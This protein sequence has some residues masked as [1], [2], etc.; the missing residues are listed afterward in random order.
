M[1]IRHKKKKEEKKKIIASRQIIYFYRNRRVEL[2]K[3]GGMIQISI[4]SLSLNKSF[5]LNAKIRSASRV[6]RRV[7]TYF[8][9][10]PFFYNNSQTVHILQYAA[11][12]FSLLFLF[13]S[14]LSCFNI[15]FFSKIFTYKER[16]VLLLLQLR[17]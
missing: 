17:K 13:L 4:L 8:Y 7:L 6:C 10:F 5:C 3:A 15:L 9:S 2:K 14:R 11:I 16:I 1:N 12:C